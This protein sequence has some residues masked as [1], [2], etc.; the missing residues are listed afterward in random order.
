MSN[1]LSVPGGGSIFTC[2]GSTYLYLEVC[3]FLLEVGLFF[4]GVGLSVPAGGFTCVCRW[5]FM[6]M[7][8]GLSVQGGGQSV[9]GGGGE[10]EE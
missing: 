1:C 8:L 4:L 9:P 5:L 7:E 3:P 2:S 10:V 6:Y